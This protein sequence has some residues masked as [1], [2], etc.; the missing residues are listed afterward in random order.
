M[1]SRS[2]RCQIAGEG[3]IQRAGGLWDLVEGSMGLA[4]RGW[5]NRVILREESRSG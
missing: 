3:D 1:G 2:K 4:S 5:H